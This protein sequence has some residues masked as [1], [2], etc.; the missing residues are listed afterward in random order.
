MR[1]FIW[2]WWQLLWSRVLWT[3]WFAMVIY[4]AIAHGLFTSQDPLAQ[5]PW[6]VGGLFAI[7]ILVSFVGCLEGWAST[8]I[9]K[10]DDY[11]IQDVV[12]KH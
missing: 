10:G 1:R 12:G 3:S 4:F 9:K 8:Y 11:E 6:S 7:M 5:L 2:V